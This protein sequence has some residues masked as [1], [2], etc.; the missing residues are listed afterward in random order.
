M[1]ICCRIPSKVRST[2]KVC[3]YKVHT[4]SEN[5]DEHHCF[6]YNEDVYTIQKLKTIHCYANVM[7]DDKRNSKILHILEIKK[8]K[9]Y[10][11]ENKIHGKFSQF[12]MNTLFMSMK[13]GK[14]IIKTIYIYKMLYINY[15][16]SF[17]IHS[18][19][20]M[21]VFHCCVI[22]FMNSKLIAK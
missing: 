2:I 18:R 17:F 15:T 12:L 6:R 19:N 16:G 3:I 7:K 22:N 10:C 14:N 8:M 20:K 11:K 13:K 9:K 1:S 4:S 21:Y 5:N